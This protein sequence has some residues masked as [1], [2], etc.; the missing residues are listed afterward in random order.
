M[1]TNE[2]FTCYTLAYIHVH[3]LGAWPKWTYTDDHTDSLYIQLLAIYIRY[4]IDR[5]NYQLYVLNPLS[6]YKEKG[7]LFFYGILCMGFQNVI[8]KV[9]YVAYLILW[10]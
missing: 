10:W 9:P 7:E 4:K 1:L 3:T 5:Y 2:L 8:L 6:Y